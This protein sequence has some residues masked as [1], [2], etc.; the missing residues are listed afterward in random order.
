MNK[1]GA[2]KVAMEWSEKNEGEI[3]NY[4]YASWTFVDIWL[5][6]E[7]L[8]DKKHINFKTTSLSI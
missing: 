2:M 3:L 4:E 1:E 8:Y 6:I 5:F 7:W